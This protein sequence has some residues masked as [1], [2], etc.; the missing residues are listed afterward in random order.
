ME[1]NN[2][3]LQK[4]LEEQYAILE[5]EIQEDKK[6]KRYL[7]VFII[8][9][10]MFLMIFG[11]TFSYF[12]LYNDTN[13]KEF[14]N[15]LEDL[16]VEG[17]EDAFDFEP[18]VKGY[19]LRVKKGTT[20]VN[21]K[22][23]LGCQNCKVD[24]FGADNLKEGLNEVVVKVSDNINEETYIIYVEVE[25]VVEEPKNPVVEEQV[26]G[27][28]NIA[29]SDHELD[30]RF[31][32]NKTIYTVDGIKSN[33]D[34]II[35]TVELL[36]TTDKI[37]YKLNGAKVTRLPNYNGNLVDI[38]FNVSS[39][40]VLGANNL[41]IK[42]TDAKGNEKIYNLILNVDE[43]V[44]EQIVEITVSYG[45]SDGSYIMSN[46][47]PGWVSSEKQHI[48]IKN[49]SNYDTNIDIKW[50]DVMNDFTNTKDLVYTLYKENTVIKSGT[51]PVKEE[52]IISNLKIDANSNTNYYIS[53]KYLY[54]ENDQNID[55]GKTFSGKIK[56]Q[57]SK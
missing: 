10:G 43:V 14:K 18:D 9:L 22:Y 55:Q 57:L 26:V 5:E 24:I 8:F 41:E 47:I 35:V 45:N 29:V 48:N 38:K 54:S 50:T 19:S 56:V 25:K 15:M 53:Y 34:S 40:L 12:R 6:K 21:L 52:L 36:N 33:E 16:Y 39:E 37:E 51:L 20:S 27:L 3:E 42:V 13:E 44:E 2:D 7:I 23:V 32:I 30:P 11:T 49:G 4:D 17:Y 28:K 46:I 1:I 31:E